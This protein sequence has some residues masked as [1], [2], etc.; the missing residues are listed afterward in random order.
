MK[1]LRRLIARLTGILPDKHREAELSAELEAHISLATDANLRAGMSPNEAHRQAVLSLG[2]VERTR[3][4]YREGSTL[5]LLD[6]LLHDLTFAIRQLRKN[7]GFTL[8][9]IL[10]LALGTCAAVSIFAFVDAALVKPLPYKDPSHLV[11]VFERVP[12]YVHSNL[13]Y[14]DYLDWKARNTVF[15][16]LDVYGRMG[17]LMTTPSGKVLVSAARVSDGFF[18]T[19]GIA[20]VLGRD[21]RPGEDL[22][23]APRTALLSYATWQ[24]TFNQSPSVIGQSVTINDEPVTVIGVLPPE[25]HFAPIG[26]PDFILSLN[27][28]GSCDKR[29][30]CHSLFGLARLK[31]EAT[32]ATALAN[33]LA[34]A[35]QLEN[36]HP[37]DNRGQGANVI[38]LTDYIVGDIRPILLLLLGGAALL[39]FIACV[40]VASLLL[41][42]SESRRREIAIRGALGASPA[43]ITRQFVTEAALLVGTGTAIGLTLAAIAMKLLLALIPTGMLNQMPFFQGIGLNPRILGFTAVIALGA[44]LVFALTPRL[45]L[46]LHHVQQ[47]L[48]DGSRGVSGMAWRRFGANLVIIELATAMV[49]LVGAGLLGKSLYRLLHVD[50]GFRPNHIA[51]LGI[52]A[53]DAQYSKEEQLTALEKRLHDRVSQLPGVVSVASSTSTPLRGSGTE[54]VRVLGRPWHG[55]HLEMPYLCVTPSYLKTLGAT[56]AQGRF[57]T[58]QDTKD[59]TRVA[60][61]NRAFA[62]AY[63]PNEDPVGHQLQHTSIA[64]E[65]P[66]LIVGIIDD[67]REGA[68]DKPITPV[69]YLPFAQGND[70]YFQLIVRTTTSEGAMLPTIIEAVHKEAPDVFA[71]SPDTMA[72]ILANSSTAYIH[73][74][75]AWLAGAFAVTAL[76]LGIVGL[77]GVVAYSVS[78]RTR[79]IGVRM[80]LGAQRTTVYKL[81]LREAGSLAIIGIA[82]GLIASIAAATTMKT[83]LF[84]TQ[85]W[86]ITTLAA[87]ATLLGLSALAASFLPAHRAASINPVDALRAE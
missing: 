7:L 75:T 68:L 84:G 82:I 10:M 69:L 56:L 29:R 18:S 36:E 1:A 2:G 74:S 21:F 23:S 52:A 44:L 60:V 58:E 33:T 47:G 22:P 81:I 67:I 11:G 40:N 31:P 34:I 24:K 70:T 35:A 46:S 45:R 83:L 20:P 4:A 5:P 8:T 38:P 66:M 43:R 28:S 49:L 63:F 57:F 16:S 42:R 54:W 9:A 41:V 62:R 12:L 79:E 26:T 51:T 13:S 14:P 77:Y 3:Q 32:V 76:L 17:G 15:S 19:L 85:A 48:A 27:P 55:E 78:Q 53:P 6:D 50:L 25:F 39:L 80:A 73:R 30:S 86:D 64:T 37:T 61:I 87:V 65:S 72:L 71:D 59:T